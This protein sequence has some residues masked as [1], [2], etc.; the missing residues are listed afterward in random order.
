MCCLLFVVCWLVGLFVCLF[1]AKQATNVTIICFVF[2]GRPTLHDTDRLRTLI[3]MLAS[4]LAMSIAYSG[5]SYATTM[6]ASSL[7]PAGQ[8]SEVL[9]GLTQVSTANLH[10]GSC[11]TLFIISCR[12]LSLGGAG[13][14]GRGWDSL[15]EIIWNLRLR[16]STMRCPVWFSS[17]PVWLDVL[18]GR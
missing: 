18:C 13:R 10:W 2:L 4:D 7:T 17:C 5:H 6:A 1:R 9:S 8:L 16:T 11:W 12:N 3:N 14:G 15:R